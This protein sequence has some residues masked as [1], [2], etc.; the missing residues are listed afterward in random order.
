MGV[1]RVRITLYVIP[2][3]GVGNLVM[4]FEIALAIRNCIVSCSAF[5]LLNA[6]LNKCKISSTPRC[7]SNC[8][9]YML[10]MFF[11]RRFLCDSETDTFIF[12]RFLLVIKLF[13]QTYLTTRNNFPCGQ[14]SL[15]ENSFIFVLCF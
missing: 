9:F 7:I 4:V 13:S 2:C 8:I 14:T 10:P 6:K 3:E 1:T 12:L 15:I 11:R 5:N